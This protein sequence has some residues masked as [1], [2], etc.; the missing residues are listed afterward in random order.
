MVGIDAQTFL[1]KTPNLMLAII[2]QLVRL[3]QELYVK[4]NLARISLNIT[5]EK[6]VEQQHLEEVKEDTEE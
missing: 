4:K 5:R 2:W 3:L 6:E 1:D